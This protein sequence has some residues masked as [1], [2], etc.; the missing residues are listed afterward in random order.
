MLFILQ[1]ILE[2]M[3]NRQLTR[4]YQDLIKVI[5][6]GGGSIPFQDTGLSSSPAMEEDICDTRHTTEVISELGQRVLSC[7][8]V[9]QA[10]TVYLFRYFN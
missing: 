5:L 3:V 7:E 4:E 10:V 8:P 6:V 1:E 2:D 9:L